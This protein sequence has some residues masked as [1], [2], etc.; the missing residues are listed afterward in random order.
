MWKGEQCAQLRRQGDLSTDRHPT[1]RSNG[2]VRRRQGLSAAQATRSRRLPGQRSAQSSGTNMSWVR[3]VSEARKSARKRTVGPVTAPDWRAQLRASEALPA[4]RRGLALE[5]IVSD[6]FRAQHFTVLRGAGAARPRQTD[7]LAVRPPDRYLIECKWQRRPADIADLDSLRSRLRR[8]TGDVSGLLI[9]MSGFS[10]PAQADVLSHRDQ[11]VLLLSGEELLGAVGWDDQLLHLLWRKRE[12]LLHDGR[13]LLDGG[14]HS[15]R[16]R[17]EVAHPEPEQKFALPSG[18]MSQV[19]RGDGGFGPL[20]YSPAPA[21]VDALSVILD[22]APPVRSEAGL[23]QLVDTL[24]ELGWTSGRAR[25]RINQAHASW[26]GAGAA[27]FGAELP[28]WRVRAD[29]RDAHESEEVFYV[30]VCDGGGYTLSASLLADQ[31]RIAREVRLSFR[32]AG[33]PLDAAP[34]LQLC[35]SLGVHNALYFRPRET[36][37]AQRRTRLQLALGS[38][39]DV[40]ARVVSDVEHGGAEPMVSGVVVANPFWADVEDAEACPSAPAGLELLA[41]SQYLICDLRQW[42]GLA[43]RPRKYQLDWFDSAWTSDVFMCSP[44]ADWED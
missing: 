42:H 10:A 44:V 29:S 15:R 5:Q 16:R 14:R 17:V 13:L 9:S 20:V 30:D 35:R 26:H 43:R 32:L 36:D 38:S 22:I 39:D 7:V 2:P 40:V 25:W 6:I 18:T 1:V 31:R 28:Q 4:P 3:Y 34:L 37:D 33:V 27:A 8:T 19:I 12:A 11:P 23:R 21:H 41:R 24:T